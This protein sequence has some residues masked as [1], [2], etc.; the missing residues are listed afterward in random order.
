MRNQKLWNE[1]H[2]QSHENQV[3]V[4]K[5]SYYR[6]Q[7][8]L[9]GGEMRVGG[10]VLAGPAVLWRYLALIKFLPW[11]SG[12]RK[13]WD[14][15]LPAQS[16]FHSNQFCCSSVSATPRKRLG[17]CARRRECVR[18]VWLLMFMQYRSQLLHTWGMRVLHLASFQLSNVITL[19]LRRNG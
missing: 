8:W 4:V 1:M 15:N 14:E 3:C 2:P 18:Q 17:A 19:D 11:E 7:L 10:V 6:L 5:M 16:E 12:R 13:K 9:R